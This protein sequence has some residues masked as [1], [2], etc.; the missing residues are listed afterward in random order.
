MRNTVRIYIDKTRILWS[1]TE[2]S[3]YSFY[4]WSS[5]RMSIRHYWCHSYKYWKCKLVY[6]VVWFFLAFPLRKSAYKKE[7]STKTNLTFSTVEKIQNLQKEIWEFPKKY[8]TN[9][10]IQIMENLRHLKVIQ[11]NKYIM[12]NLR[13]GST[14]RRGIW[15]AQNTGR[16]TALCENTK[17]KVHKLSRWSQL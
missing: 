14:G 16:K 6:Y 1:N 17:F 10:N 5:F 3:R 12:F 4:V 2:V 11:N 13:T 7:K 8:L 9:C 15:R